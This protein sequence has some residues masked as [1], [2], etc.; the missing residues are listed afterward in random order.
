MALDRLSWGVSAAQWDRP[1]RHHRV[2]PD[3]QNQAPP[4]AHAVSEEA[5]QCQGFPHNPV[6]HHRPL[7]SAGAMRGAGTRGILT[8][9]SAW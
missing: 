5:Q 4:P 3:A 8:S 1:P 6:S 2:M 9:P 7:R